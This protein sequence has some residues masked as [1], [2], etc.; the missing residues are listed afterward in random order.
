MKLAQM[1]MKSKWC[2]ENQ[3]DGL[4][5]TPCSLKTLLWIPHVH[6]RCKIFHVVFQNRAFLSCMVA[7]FAW[8]PLLSWKTKVKV[9]VL[10][11]LY[12]CKLRIW[13]VRIRLPDMNILL[14]SHTNQDYGWFFF[15]TIW[16]CMW[17]VN[18]LLV[19]IW[20]TADCQKLLGFVRRV[21]IFLNEWL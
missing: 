19:R 1:H 10:C 4:G 15:L 3:D 12:L 16:I 5:S 17:N 7:D 8:L 20:K 13:V 18:S 21:W 6:L 9:F 11:F 14:F 2:A